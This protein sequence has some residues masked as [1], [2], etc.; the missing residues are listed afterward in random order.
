MEDL[1]LAQRIL[2]WIVFFINWGN[3]WI[4]SSLMGTTGSALLWNKTIF[5]GW[6]LN[7][8]SKYF[9]MPP[10]LLLLDGLVPYHISRIY[11]MRYL[12]NIL[13]VETPSLKIKMA[14]LRI[15]YTP[16]PPSYNSLLCSAPWA[17]TLMYWSSDYPISRR[18]WRFTNA[19]GLLTKSWYIPMITIL[20]ILNLQEFSFIPPTQ[21]LC[22]RSPYNILGYSR[23]IILIWCLVRGE[24]E[25]YRLSVWPYVLYT[26]WKW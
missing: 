9:S 23:F 18:A 14:S 22:M 19:S 26:H 10:F 15:P 12:V 5:S 11:L 20:L 8:A 21:N 1:L 7:L 3:K 4:I 13:L 25:N 24:Q 16:P 17:Y 2:S 6:S